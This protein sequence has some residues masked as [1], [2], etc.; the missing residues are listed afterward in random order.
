MFSVCYIYIF[1]MFYMFSVCCISP[2]RRIIT[3]EKE[4]KKSFWYLEIHVSYFAVTPDIR[5]LAAQA[6]AGIQT[7]SHYQIILQT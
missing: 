5:L 1:Y 6:L 2:L 3:I 7:E 4:K